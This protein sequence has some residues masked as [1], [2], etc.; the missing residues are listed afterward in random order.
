M[1]TL[2]CYVRLALPALTIAG[3]LF[4]PNPATAAQ[5]TFQTK[6]RQAIMIDFDTGTVLFE[7]DSNS[8]MF[9]AS[10]SK[11]MTALLVFDE[12]RA[13]RLQMD[14]TF[15]VSEKAWRMGGS[16]MFVSIN[17]E[18][19]IADLLRG[20]IVQ[21][22]NDASIVIAEGI[23]GTEESFAERMTE[24]AREIG[25]TGTQFRNA[26]GWPDPEHYTTARDLATLAI[27]LI[28]EYPEF[29]TLYSEREFTYGKSLQGKPISQGNRNPLLY[30]SVGADGLKTGYTEASGFGLTA[31]AVRGERRLVMVINGLN[32]VRARSSESERLINWG[33]RVFDNYPLFQAGDTVEEAKVWLG[34]S[35]TVPLVIDEPLTVT[36]P[37]SSRRGMQ[38]KVMYDS[39]IPAPVVAGAE[40]ARIEITAPDMQPVLRPLITAQDI[41]RLAFFG[42]IKS[43]IDFII[44]GS[45]SDS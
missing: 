37:K 3:L 14:S 15:R 9:P 42:R 7:K 10:M 18:I 43:A 30:T 21:S 24:R 12:L 34:D 40:V 6:A 26:T 8:P 44:F 32:S 25:L 38:V 20:V 23:S 29:Y 39:P 33:F 19:K 13:G 36:I 31:S 16:K 2:S 11:I 28:R 22:G 17:T 41:D 27:F 4:G 45:S 5:P 35:G 1:K